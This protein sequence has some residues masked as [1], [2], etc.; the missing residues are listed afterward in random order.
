MLMLSA[1]PAHTPPDHR[2][3]A[4][5]DTSSLSSVPLTPADQRLVSELSITKHM[6]NSP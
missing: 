6:A 5:H 3:S 4:D 1:T 2:H